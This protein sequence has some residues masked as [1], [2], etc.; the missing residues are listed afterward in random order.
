M[1]K[2][3]ISWGDELVL[4]IKPYIYVRL[5]DNLLIL[6]PNQA[7]KLNESG[8]Y[9]LKE[10]LEGRKILDILGEKFGEDIPQNVIDDMHEADGLI[11]NI[12]NGINDGQIRLGRKKNRGFGLIKINKIYYSTFNFDNVND[13]IE[14]KNVV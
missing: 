5:K 11:S 6:V 13:Y 1:T 2:E 9:I 4:N 7:Y 14:F 3:E 10:M 12:I 8:L